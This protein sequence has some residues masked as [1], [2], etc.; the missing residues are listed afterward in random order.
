M[1]YKRDR[2]VPHIFPKEVNAAFGTSFLT[3]SDLSEEYCSLEQV[4]GHRIVEILKNSETKKEKADGMVTNEKQKMLVVRTSDCVPILFCDTV[5]GFIGASHQGWK[6]TLEKMP[7]KMVDHFK[8]N[9]S[10]A[11]NIKVAI[12]PC[13]GACCYKIYGER[14]NLFEA[15]FPE[16]Q[17]KIF[18]RNND[19]SI[20][21]LLRLNYEMLVSAGIDSKNI[22]YVL[23]CTRCHSEIF[24]SY[25]RDNGVVSMYSFIEKII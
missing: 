19:D 6:G 21:N 13:I 20:L 9:G 15:S 4:H 17:D 2:I 24:S 12:G 3:L 14:K 1:I 16:L 11:S 25:N 7:Q 5:T 22:E 10:L 8:V 23:D 18:V